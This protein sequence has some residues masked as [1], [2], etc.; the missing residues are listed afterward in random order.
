MQAIPGEL[1]E[2]ASIDGANRW[3][4]FRNVT[5]PALR[6]TILFT[7]IISTMGSLQ[8]FGEPRLFGEGNTGLNGGSDGQFNTL[9]LYVYKT[10]FSS[11]SLGRAAAIAW[12]IFFLAVVAGAANAL[13]ARRLRKS[14]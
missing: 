1:Y 5:I 11:E 12:V 10:A 6:P 2:A 13:I 3:Q 7:V 4:Q 8:L 14:S 9:A